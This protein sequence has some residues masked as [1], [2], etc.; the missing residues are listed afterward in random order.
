M[1]FRST[2]WKLLVLS[3]SI[4]FSTALKAQDVA[5]LTGLVTDTTGAVIAGANVELVNT[6]TNATYKAVTTGIGSYTITDVAPGPGHTVTFS[7][8]GFESVVVSNLYLNVAT[9][10]TQ[11]ARLPVGNVSST[12]AVS[13]TSDDVTLDT[14]DATVGN[15][16]NMKMV[17][18]LPVYNRTNP[19]VLFT[20][21]PGTSSTGAVTGARED[22]NSVTLDGLDVNDI[23]AGGEPGSAYT[24]VANAPV[25][26]VQEFRGTVAGPLSNSGPGGGGAFQ[27]VTKGGTNEFHG[28]VN[29]YL[30]NTDATA[31]NWFDNDAGVARAPLIRNQFGGNL[32]GPV[33]KN[34]LFFFF[35]YDGSR[36]AESLAEERNVPLNSFRNGTISYITNAPG[37]DPNNS[38]QNTTPNCIAGLTATPSAATAGASTVNLDPQGIGVNAQ[39]LAFVNSRYPM[40]NDLTQGDGVNSGGFRFNSPNPDTL[41]NYV[42]RADYTLNDANKLFARV[43]FARENA[44]TPGLS[45]QFAGDPL[46]YPSFD[47]S[48]A[49]VA[50]W[51]WTI[52]PSKVNQLYYGSTVSVIDFPTKYDPTGVDN[53]AFNSPFANPY[54]NI[55]DQQ[56]RR[57][58]IPVVRDDFSWQKGNHDFGFGGTFKFIKTNSSLISD[59]YF[60]TVGLGGENLALD[61]ALRPSNIG[62]SGTAATTTFDSA[63]AF[64]LGAYSQLGANYDYDNKGSVLQQGSGAARHYRYYQTELYFGDT[65]KATKNLTLSYGV[66]YMLYSVPYETQGL[67]SIQNT[68]FDSYFDARLAQSAAGASGATAVPFI[69]YSLGGKANHAAGM[70]KP[71]YN[72]FAPR[73]A[74]AYTPTNSPKTVFNGSAN[75]IFD[76]TVINAVNFIQDQS[77][78]LFQA[79]A[80]NIYGLTDPTASLAV[81]PRF[82]SIDSI[83]TPPV[84][85]VITTPYT[86]YVS[87][88]GANATPFGLANGEFQT[89]IDPGLRNPYSIAF[90]AGFQHEFPDHFVLKTSYV[91]RLG[92]RLIAQADAS[93]LI[94]NPDPTSGQMMSTA[95]ANITKQLRQGVNPSNVTAQPWFDNQF[96]YGPYSGTQVVTQFYGVLAQR[97]DFADTIQALSADGFLNYN[98]GMAAQL[99]EDT[100]ITN[101]GSSNYHGMLVTLSK[102]LS[103]GLQFDVNYTWSHSIDNTSLIANSIASNSGVGFICDVVRPRECRGNSDFDTRNVITSD[104]LYDLPFGRGNT[105]AANVPRWIDEVIGGWNVDGIPAWHS[106]MPFNATSNAYVA[107]YANNAPA[108][109][110]GANGAIQSHLNKTSS[111]AVYWY[112]NPATVLGDFTGPVGFGVGGRNTLRGPGAF[113]FDA[114]LGKTFPVV[115]K[116]N[117]KFR[118][119]AFNALNHPVFSNPISDITSSEFGQITG[120]LT[121]ATNGAFTNTGARVMQFSLRVEF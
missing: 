56:R 7:R 35:D 59:D 39:L 119:D 10:R 76:R 86:P 90:N 83:P 65:W 49:Y 73:F 45:N 27:M 120:T 5:S 60:P 106:G 79:S 66:K 18:E 64:A 93:Q 72:N 25:D 100:F 55:A 30:R 74:F 69:S 17:D 33:I 36:V 6:A 68:G 52:S 85:P 16:F 115:E 121:S 26:S 67:E 61:P 111:G 32:G 95:F 12:V 21:Q 87:G 84:A 15:N 92:R 28:N 97:G 82:T 116:V 29:E 118:A 22:Q 81:E 91:G 98:V 107:G 103:Q 58:P 104:V 14:T 105:F 110:T 20:M 31:N 46:T 8:D 43:T 112:S 101:K 44:V 109:F 11:N 38:R 99:A 70:Y 3:L 57:V 51:T 62:A 1:Q 113:T 80:A 42:G 75:I 48:Y 63:Y 89:A 50:G 53:F 24:I 37:C 96:S 19:T 47:E 117:V 94:D 23:A 88:V 4:V 41:N 34:K 114:G 9:T 108:I 102:N 40:A 77:S 71:S 54:G 13:A 78:Y 2:L